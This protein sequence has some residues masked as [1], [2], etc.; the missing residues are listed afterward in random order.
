VNGLAGPESSL[1]RSLGRWSLTA[2]VV[3][4]IIGTSVFILP[5]TLGGGLG[6]LSLAAWAMA[7]ILSGTIILCFAEVASRFAGAGGAYLFTQVAFGQFVGMQ[8][9]WLSYFVRCITGAVQSNVFV[10]YM[11]EFWPW[12]ATR[13]GALVVTGLFLAVLA[14]VNVRGVGSGA[15]VSNGFALVKVVPLIGLGL[16]GLIWLVSQGSPVSHVGSDLTLTSWLEALLLLMFAFGGFETAVIPLAEAKNPRRD[17]PTALLAGLAVATVLYLAAQV[18]VLATLAEPAATDRPLASSARVMLG[19]TG[20]SFIS[21]AALISVYGWLSSN[22]LA[23]P[24]L[25]MALADNGDFPRFFSNV[26]PVFRTPWISIVLFA[27]V[28]WALANLAGLL[29]NLSLAAVSR[30]FTYG[31]VCAALPVLRRKEAN[32][33][34]G[35][36]SAA[37]RVPAGTVVAGVGVAGS[38]ILATRMSGREAIT[39]ALVVTLATG[40]WVLRRR[41]SV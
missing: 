30:L 2:L 23:V 20:A 17:I 32:A 27:A 16:A 38:L 22:M 10:T 1:V 40:Y 12:A 34:R 35:V 4:G 28:A 25:S 13:T 24:R 9:G 26:H 21:V 29:Q 6:W 18:T 36:P 41:R 8:V 31:L 19:G 33:K 37:F 5:G 11:A 3:N 39:M 15:R 14:A 7:A